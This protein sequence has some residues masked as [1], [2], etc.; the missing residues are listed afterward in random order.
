MSCFD[1]CNQTC[2]QT[3][4]QNSS[5]KKFVTKTRWLH[6]SYRFGY[7]PKPK[8]TRGFIYACNQRNQNYLYKIK[9]IYIRAKKA[10]MHASGRA[11]HVCA[12]VGYAGYNGMLA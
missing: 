6:S 5:Y 1:F 8:V 12:R 4:N 9:Y 10:R 2:N 7:I 3:C 11:L